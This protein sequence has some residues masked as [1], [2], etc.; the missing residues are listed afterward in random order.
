MK[1]SNKFKVTLIILILSFFILSVLLFF[2]IV[3]F[4]NPNRNEFPISG[5]DVSNHQGEIEWELVPKDKIQF[6]YIKATEGG[7]FVDKRFN[8]NIN[9]AKENGFIT[10]AYHFFT[11][12]KSGKEQAA[13]FI[14]NVDRRLII[15][16]PAID[17]EFV[18]NCSFR[19]TTNVFNKDLLEFILEIRNE[20]LKEPIIYTTYDFLEQYPLEIY[21]L[22]Y[23]IRDIFFMP[24]K[25]IKWKIW[26]YT[27]RESFPGIDGYIDMNVFHGDKKEFQNWINR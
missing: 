8:L 22:D 9:K 6:V 3:W 16:P 20:Y 1:L 27:E 19:P 7:D 13:N 12:C 26:Q 24:R 2:G 25:N 18:G 5:I 14:K 17:L 21:Q 23:W 15:L 10:G 11:L 4:N